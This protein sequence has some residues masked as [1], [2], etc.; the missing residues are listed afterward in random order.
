MPPK[1]PQYDASI[2]TT[3]A[4]RLYSQASTITLKYAFLGCLVGLATGGVAG[5]MGGAEELTLGLALV[6]GVFGAVLGVAAAAERAFMLRLQAQ[7]IL[8]QV[9]IERNTRAASSHG[10]GAMSA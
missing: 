1:T 3:M 2:L 7:S 8:V 10:A 6:L 5:V 9:Q 4:A